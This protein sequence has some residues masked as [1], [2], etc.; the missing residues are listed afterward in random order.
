MA[1]APR[2]ARTYRVRLALDRIQQM[3]TQPES[4]RQ[5]LRE[6][7]ESK[8]VGRSVCHSARRLLKAW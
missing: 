7:A 8:A 4:L 1:S 6:T 5:G 3:E 2:R